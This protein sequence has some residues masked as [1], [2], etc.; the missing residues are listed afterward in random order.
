MSTSPKGWRVLAARHVSGP[1]R[2]PPTG[3][4]L[5]PSVSVARSAK[6]AHLHDDEGE[7]VVLLRVVDP[8]FH[9]G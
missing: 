5:Y 4:P 7:I 6:S 8:V 9:L 3:L 1:R 2:R